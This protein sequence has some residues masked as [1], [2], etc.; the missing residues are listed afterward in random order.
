M[1]PSWPRLSKEKLSDG[2]AR[3]KNTRA[4][5]RIRRDQAVKKEI[6]EDEAVERN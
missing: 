4:K 2:A 3:D 6:R 5:A 1:R